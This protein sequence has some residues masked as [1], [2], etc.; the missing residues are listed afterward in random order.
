MNAFLTFL[1]LFLFAFVSIISAILTS[2]IKTVWSVFSKYVFISFAGLITCFFLVFCFVK[3][4]F[5]CFFRI[6]WVCPYCQFHFTSFSPLPTCLRRITCMDKTG[7]FGKCV[8]PPLSSC[9]NPFE[10]RSRLLYLY[11]RQAFAEKREKGFF[12]CVRFSFGRERICR[13]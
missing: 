4:G 6:T 7:P 2:S 11:K 12:L 3:V 13:P 1:K 10:L 8:A 5:V 9:Y